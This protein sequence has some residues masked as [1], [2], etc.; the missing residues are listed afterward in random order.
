MGLGQKNGQ[1]KRGLAPFFRTLQSTTFHRVA[2]RV[3]QTTHPHQGS[4]LAVVQMRS[5]Q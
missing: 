2:Q 4:R 5:S 1:E 3:E